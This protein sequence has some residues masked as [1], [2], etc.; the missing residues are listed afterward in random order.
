MKLILSFIVAAAMLGAI[1]PVANAQETQ[2]INLALF[3]PVQIFKNDVPIKGF[4][5]NLIYGKNAAMTGLDIGLVNWVTGETKGFQWGAVNI[6]EGDFTGWQ[7]GPVTKT[8]G[9]ILG[10]QSGWLVSL[11]TSGKGLQ[12]SGVTISDDYIG[13][14]F[15]FVNYAVQLH[16][17]Q[18]GLI[19]IIKNGGMLPVFPFF[20]FSFDE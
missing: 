15:G 19:N 11:N 17:I 13:L 8:D 3:D 4:R 18:I 16:G 1:A 5:F 2:P 20:N 7:N 10:V 12:V 6:T 14:Q 9:H